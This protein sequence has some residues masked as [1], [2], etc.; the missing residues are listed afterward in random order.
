M[1]ANNGIELA[2]LHL[3]GHGALVFVGGVEVAGSSAGY[4]FD[5]FTCA[6]GHD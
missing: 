1:L 3:L 5:L 4:Q 2:D 6:L